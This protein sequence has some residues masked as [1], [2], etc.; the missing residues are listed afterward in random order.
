[1]NDDILFIIILLILSLLIVFSS[2]TPTIAFGDYMT[3][4]YNFPNT[5]IVLTLHI[6]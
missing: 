4:M 1:M 3:L 6:G 2:L 5:F